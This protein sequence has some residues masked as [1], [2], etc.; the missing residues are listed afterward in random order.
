MSGQTNQDS[1]SEQSSPWKDVV[2]VR[3]LGSSRVHRA[4]VAAADLVEATHWGAPC[5]LVALDRVATLCGVILRRGDVIR[6][7]ADKLDSWRAGR[8]T[9][10]VACERIEALS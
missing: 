10:C 6:I 3:S 8:N 4:E 2:A 5:T 7:P 1:G 9:V